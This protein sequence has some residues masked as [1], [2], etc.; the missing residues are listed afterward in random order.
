MNVEN[1]RNTSAGQSRSAR[2]AE[3]DGV[4]QPEDTVPRTARCQLW[5]G[6]DPRDP[7]VFLGGENGSEKTLSVRIVPGGRVE[8]RIKT[9]PLGVQRDFCD[10]C[11]TY[12]G[13][14]ITDLVK[15]EYEVLLV[16]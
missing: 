16:G 9:E 3:R 13:T 2:G 14:L 8:L 5:F 12:G 15:T 10:A 4:M 7:G 1:A 11:Q 6:L